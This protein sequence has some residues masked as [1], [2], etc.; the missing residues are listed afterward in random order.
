[1]KPVSH[2][3]GDTLTILFQLGIAA[4]PPLA[5]VQA[6]EEGEQSCSTVALSSSVTENRK[7]GSAYYSST[8][9][10]PEV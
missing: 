5:E 2:N 7:E 8:L 3:P 9:L 10:T 6:Q 4:L 1:M